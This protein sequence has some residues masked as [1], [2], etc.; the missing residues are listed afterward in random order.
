M[1]KV[2]MV[3]TRFWND[4]FISEL[5]PIEKLLFIYFITNEHTNICGVYELPLK[6]S[7]VETGIDSSMFQKILPRLKPK[8]YYLN[9]WVI[10][11]NFPK[12]QSMNLPKVKLGFQEAVKNIPNKIKEFMAKERLD[13]CQYI[14]N[15]LATGNSDSDSDSDSKK[16]DFSEKKSPPLSYKKIE[17]QTYKTARQFTNQRRAEIGKS[18][19]QQKMTKKQ[20]DYFERSKLVDY[21]KEAVNQEHGTKYFTHPE[22]IKNVR[23][24]NAKISKNMKDFYARCD[25]KIEKAK[26]VI[27]WFASGAG[28]WCEYSPQGCFRKD[29]VVGFENT[30]TKDNEKLK[31]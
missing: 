20:V 10:I 5:D 31:L 6:I 12:Y 25:F 29:T 15:E 22:D 11:N 27:N 7:A 14:A 21:F 18:P 13:Y 8:I 2:R 19:L 9:G 4:Y 3:N 26:E 24:E 28:E 17:K 1:A 23:S 16:S 30:Q